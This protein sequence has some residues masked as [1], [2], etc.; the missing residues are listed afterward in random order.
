[1]GLKI[2]LFHLELAN[3]IA[4]SIPAGHCGITLGA[5]TLEQKDKLR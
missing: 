4:A 5:E 2:S 1:M 3:L